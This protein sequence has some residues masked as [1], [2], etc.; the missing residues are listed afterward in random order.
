MTFPTLNINDVG[1]NVPVNVHVSSHRCVWCQ[2]ASHEVPA[3]N[4]NVGCT[5]TEIP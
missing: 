2:D 4:Q 1:N 3:L 5:V